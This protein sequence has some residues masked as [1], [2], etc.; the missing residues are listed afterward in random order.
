MFAVGIG[1]CATAP[2]TEKLRQRVT[3][4]MLGARPV[5]D[6]S[7]AS[8]VAAS[9]SASGSGA[10][11]GGDATAEAPGTVVFSEPFALEGGK[12]VA[13]Y[14]SAPVRNSWVY[15]ALDLVNEVS[16]GVNSFDATVEYY[17]GV[18]D[19]EAW[20]EGSTSEVH[21][22]GP[23]E[24]GS[25]VLRVEAQH[26]GAGDVDLGIVVRQGVF[27]SAWFAVFLGVLAVPFALVGVHARRFHTRRWQNSPIGRTGRGASA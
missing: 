14:L 7:I 9:G 8:A 6:P 27:R 23:V 22:I 12:N 24:P 25:Y 18:E 4:P 10:A 13:F 15:A 2:A 3:V 20:S 16:G 19:G 26:G 1:R 21:V 5:I 11:A 17:A